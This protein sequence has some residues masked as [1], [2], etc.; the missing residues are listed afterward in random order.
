MQIMSAHLCVMYRTQRNGLT[1]PPWSNT[2]RNRMFKPEQTNIGIS[3]SILQ[4]NEEKQYK[5]KSTNS[6]RIP[7]AWVTRNCITPV[8]PDLTQ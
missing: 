6:V 4:R 5:N 1:V 8:S 2:L 7:A 3:K